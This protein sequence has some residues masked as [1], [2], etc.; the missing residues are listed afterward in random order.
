MSTAIINGLRIS[1]TVEGA[2][3]PLVLLHGGLGN[4]TSWS[5]QIPYF[6]K[7]YTVVAWDAPGCGL[8]SD[9]PENFRLS[10]YADCLA[11]LLHQLDIENPNMLGLSFG[12]GL[13]LEFY[14]HYPQIPSSLIL[15]STYAGWRGSLSTK[16]VE[17]ILQAGMKQS[18]MAPEQI[19]QE[20]LPTL[21]SESVTDEIVQKMKLIIM[22]FHPA[23]MRTM[24]RSFAESDLHSVLP[25]ILVPTLLVYG[26]KDTRS[27]VDT[28]AMEL[29]KQIPKSVLS[30][31]PDVG[32][33]GNMETPENFNNVVGK[34]LKSL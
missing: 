25:N 26:E 6:S 30:V 5:N 12:G 20:W 28:V 9:P 33:L 29:H 34:F 3:K 11:G 1:Y 32:H 13:A 19:A 17:R 7:D 8:S 21:F 14:A 24:L 27:P 22:D 15:A 18:Q 10:D 16:E 4:K 31:L 2:G 23:G